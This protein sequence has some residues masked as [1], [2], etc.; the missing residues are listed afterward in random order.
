IMPTKSTPL[1][2]ATVRRIIKENVDV[3]VVIAAEQARQ[4]NARNNASG[5]GQVRGQVTAP[6]V[7]IV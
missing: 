3:D 4:A 6:V 5:S 2:Q 7:K 1:T